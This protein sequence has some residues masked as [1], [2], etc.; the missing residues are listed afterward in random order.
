MERKVYKMP[1]T[2]TEEQLRGLVGDDGNFL[3]PVIDGNGN[4]VL[5]EEE[6]NGREFQKYKALYPEIVEQFELIDWVE[7]PD[8]IVN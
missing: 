1:E 5:S 4:L 2:V 7:N 6:F 3:N 8:L